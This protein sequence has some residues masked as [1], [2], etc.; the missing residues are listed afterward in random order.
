MLPPPMK[1][2]MAMP[3]DCDERFCPIESSSSMNRMQA[4]RRP[5]SACLR[6]Q[7]ARVAE[8]FHDHQLGHADEHALERVESM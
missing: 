7:P 1:P 3:P 2:P 4:P 5:G 8:Q 6:A